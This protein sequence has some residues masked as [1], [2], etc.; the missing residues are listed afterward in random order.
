MSSKEQKNKINNFIFTKGKSRIKRGMLCKIKN[1]D[2]GVCQGLMKDI[3]GTTSWTKR[4]CICNNKKYLIL[5]QQKK[6]TCFVD[7]CKNGD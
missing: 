6:S 7:R 2:W 5:N 1:P 4:V 3:T